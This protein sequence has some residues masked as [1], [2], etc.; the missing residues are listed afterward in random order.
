MSS[1]V[2]QPRATRGQVQTVLGPV[3]PSSLGP[4]SMHEH[5]LLS[6]ECYFSVPDEASGR[7][8]VDRPITMDILGSLPRSG[9][10]TATRSTCSMSVWP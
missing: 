5:L 2:T 9:R 7:W 10:H 3:E 1:F 8:L 6:L 4:T